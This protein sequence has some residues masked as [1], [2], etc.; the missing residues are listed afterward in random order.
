M[1]DD[2]NDNLLPGSGSS[3]S[4][5]WSLPQLDAYRMSHGHCVGTA[6]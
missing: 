3:G 2:A 1:Y 4:G 6:Y 5:D